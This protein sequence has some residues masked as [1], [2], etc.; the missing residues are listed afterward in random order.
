MVT[1]SELVISD[2]CSGVIRP[3]PVVVV[4]VS[5]GSVG[6]GGGLLGCD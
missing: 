1:A 2:V 6:G 4:F 5:A 3:C